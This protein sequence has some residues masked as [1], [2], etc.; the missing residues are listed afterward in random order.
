MTKVSTSYT[1]CRI[2]DELGLYS[3]EQLQ[4]I[5]VRT[6]RTAAFKN[7]TSAYLQTD[8]RLTIYDCLHALMIPSGNDAAIILA[9]EF[10]RWLFLIGDKAKESQL[11]NLNRKGKINNFSNNPNNLR[12]L[13]N[14]AYKFPNKGHEDYIEAFLTEMN[15]QAQKLRLKH[16]RFINPH[17]L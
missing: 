13:V 12:F 17:G 2:L 6:T 8:N 7:G 16:C 14:Q 4:N 15:R 5:Y 9:T 10:G 3:K 1:V 11:P